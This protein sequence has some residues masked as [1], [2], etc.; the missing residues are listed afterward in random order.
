[1]KKLFLIIVMI[2]AY[3]LSVYA[4]Y[5]KNYPITVTQPDGTVVHCF[6]TGDEFY[7]WV[8]DENG[9]TLIRDPQTGFVVYAKLE[10]D[11]LVSTGYRAGSVDPATIGLTSGLIISAE[12]RM[13]IHSEFLAKIP[14]RPVKEGYQAPRGGWNNGTL[15]NLA[16]YIR[17][18]DETEFPS[19]KANIYF[20]M[21]N[22]DEANSS[23]QYGYFKALSNEKTLI[24]TTFYPESSG[25]VIISYQDIYPR[26]YFHFR[27]FKQL[28]LR[29]SHLPYSR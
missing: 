8:H 12:K 29:K 9:F 15:N 21:H 25:N 5:E 4:Y 10:N 18:S 3:G 17:F 19:Y 11:E 1:M 13:Q 6:T 27:Q 2:F 26:S 28:M 20:D 16:I 7:R 22:K 24:P 23:S 14:E